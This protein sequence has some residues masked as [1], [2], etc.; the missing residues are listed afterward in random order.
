MVKDNALGIK[1]KSHVNCVCFKTLGGIIL[2]LFGFL[3]IFPKLLVP[4][5]IGVDTQS[6]LYMLFTHVELA[7][8]D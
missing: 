7:I 5:A 2:Q 4:G 8:V 3:E 6:L 1:L